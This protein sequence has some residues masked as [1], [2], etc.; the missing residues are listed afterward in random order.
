L[1]IFSSSLISNKSYI[2]GLISGIK[3]TLDYSVNSGVGRI[4]FN[5]PDVLNSINRE[6]AMA[7]QKAL[8]DFSNDTSV[9]AIHITGEGRAFSAGQDLEEAINTEGP[10]LHA[11]VRDHYNPIISLLRNIEKPVVCAVNGVAAGAGANIALACDIIF[12]ASSA[13]FIQAFSKIGLIP[14]SGGTFFLPRLIGFQRASALMMLGDKV[15]AEEA[16]QMGMIYKV[17]EDDKLQVESLACAE[18]L[19]KMP[20]K[21]L[22]YTKRA[23]NLSLFNNLE[24]Q[25]DVE[26]DLQ[27]RSG[28]TSDY[29]EGVQAFLE[30]RAPDFKGE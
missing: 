27:T 20:T 8:K 23:L 4:I 12:A 21:G 2:R 24:D 17:C 30:K 3:M 14:D 1:T 6:M 22:G 5:R 16:L 13:S 7:M 29:R 28:K 26:E 10:G 11:I 15:K 25:L 9:R 18:K 19:S